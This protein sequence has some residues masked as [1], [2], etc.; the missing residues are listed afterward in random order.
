[1]LKQRIVTAV[2]A[3]LIVLLALFVLP[4]S[5]TRMIVAALMLTAAWE[6]S[7]LLSM[8]SVML[9]LAYVGLA[10]VLV[11]AILILSPHVL[12]S[13]SVFA[14]AVIWW[15]FAFVW[16]FFQPMIIP[17]IVSW[18]CGML[19]IVP[20]WYSI[21]W[22]FMRDSELLLIA[23]LIVVAA[24]TGAYFAGRQFGRVKLAPAISP[25][26]S[27]E[28]VIGGMLMVSLLAVLIAAMTGKDLLTYLPLFLAAAALSIVGDLTV[29]VFKRSAGVKDSGRLFPGHGGALDRIDSISAAAPVFA[30]ATALG[31]VR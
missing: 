31:M 6:W 9:R 22:L 5:A 26:K 25:G 3:A 13:D 21:D 29:S 8:Q 4:K 19:I 2:V 23:L 17:K 20:A 1:M 10:L 12:R 15:L 16:L 11:A 27:W 7:G 24:D 28:G 30:L 14:T 18:L